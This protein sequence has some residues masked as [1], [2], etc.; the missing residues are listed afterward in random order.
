[1]PVSPCRES[2]PHRSGP[3][4]DSPRRRRQKEE[5]DP[6]LHTDKKQ[7]HEQ[8]LSDYAHQDLSVVTRKPQN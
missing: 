7:Q 2:S 4:T 1:M 5:E 8:S 6:H 3:P